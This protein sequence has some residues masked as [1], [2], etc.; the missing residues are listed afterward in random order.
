MP[1]LGFSTGTLVF[2]R[3]RHSFLQDYLLYIVI[4]VSLP[5]QGLQG[6]TRSSKSIP[7]VVSVGDVSPRIPKV[8]E[9]NSVPPKRLSLVVS[10]LA[11]GNTTATVNLSSYGVSKGDQVLYESPQQVKKGCLAVST[12]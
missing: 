12:C 3:F 5:F 6:L 9:L 8:F 11:I 10:A 1:S 7:L 4:R 2:G